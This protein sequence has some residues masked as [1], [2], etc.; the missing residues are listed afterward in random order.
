VV[1]I[2][3]SASSKL[4]KNGIGAAL[5]TGKAAASTA[6]FEGI[7]ETQFEKYYAPACQDLDQD[8]RVGKLIFRITRVIQKSPFLKRGILD[9]VGR[10]QSQAPSAFRMSSAL[11][12]TF[13]GSAGY[14]NILRRFLHPR[15]LFSLARSIVGSNISILNHHDHEKQEAR[16]TL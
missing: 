3:D 16:Q 14:R 13:T 6:I 2:G 4:Y 5:I 10:E 7:G 11:W 9:L 12:D 8:N 15:L 1:L